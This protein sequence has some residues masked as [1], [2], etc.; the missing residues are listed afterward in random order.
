MQALRLGKARRGPP[1]GEEPCL[2]AGLE[3]ALETGGGETLGWRSLA[4]AATAWGMRGGERAGL[5]GGGSQISSVATFGSPMLA[6]VE[7]RRL[8]VFVTGGG[9][10]LVW[11]T[12]AY[13]GTMGFRPSGTPAARSNAQGTALA[14]GSACWSAKHG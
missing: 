5:R 9:E 10:T 11:R 1:S 8:V 13:A 6:G 3:P 7:A 12:H 14:H 4:G 2:A